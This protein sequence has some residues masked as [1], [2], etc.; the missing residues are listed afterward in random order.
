M[1]NNKIIYSISIRDIR[2]VVKGL[3]TRELTDSELE[4]VGN[5]MG[6]FINWAD[7]IES[8]VNEEVAIEYKE[9]PDYDFY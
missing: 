4:K 3:F 8:A 1:R 6:D 2:E 9:E 5:R 7:I